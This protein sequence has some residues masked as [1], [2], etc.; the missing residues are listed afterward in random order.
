MTSSALLSEEEIKCLIKEEFSMKRKPRTLNLFYF[1]LSIYKL[2]IKKKSESYKKYLSMK[3]Y[4]DNKT[5]Y[6][7]DIFEN[8]FVV[9]SALQYIS[10]T[11]LQKEFGLMPRHYRPWLLRFTKKIVSHIPNKRCARFQWKP[12][13]HKFFFP[14]VDQVYIPQSFIDRMNGDTIFYGSYDLNAKDKNLE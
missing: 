8:M 10:T 6:E 2:D 4:Y 9:D 7:S 3:S 1:F 5:V 11:K 12:E 14:L 13:A